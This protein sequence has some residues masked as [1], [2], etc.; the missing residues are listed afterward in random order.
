[1]SQTEILSGTLRV[2]PGSPETGNRG[3]WS[4][5][6]PA[7]AQGLKNILGSGGTALVALIA[8]AAGLIAAM[9][10]R[11]GRQSDFL[12][13]AVSGM[14]L[15]G[16]LALA[17]DGHDAGQAT[18]P[19]TSEIAQRLSDGTLFVPKPTQRILAI[20]TALTQA[21]THRKTLGAAGAHH[22]RSER[23]RVC[24]GVRQ[25]PAFTAHKADFRSLARS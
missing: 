24:A 8:F 18:T 15:L 25:R 9:F 5:L 1:M 4:F 2:A 19:P 6:P 23:E 17:H 12:A 20:R 14:L 10:L 13:L 3:G 7:L 22:P 11:P 16:P 21:A